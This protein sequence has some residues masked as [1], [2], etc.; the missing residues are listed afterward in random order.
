MTK[1][2]LSTGD[3]TY[4]KEEYIIDLF[5]LHFNINPGD[6]PMKDNMGFDCSFSGVLKSELEKEIQ[7]RVSLFISQI[8]DYFDNVSVTIDDISLVDDRTANLSIT[9]NDS[10]SGTI[11]FNI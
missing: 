9:V 4:R 7:A 2:L 6:V 11:T 3:S 8:E 5:R 1:Y 10:S